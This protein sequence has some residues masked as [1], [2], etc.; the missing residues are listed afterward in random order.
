MINLAIT[1]KSKLS[2]VEVKEK[3]QREQALTKKRTDKDLSPKERDQF[4]ILYPITQ[5]ELIA[6]K[7]L[8]S[9]SDVER[10]S[11]ELQVF[12]DPA[13]TRSAMQE[14]QKGNIEGRVGKDGNKFAPGY[15]VTQMQKRVTE[16]ESR[17]IMSMLEEG[18]D[19]KQM[20][21]DLAVAC[22]FRI[23]KGMLIEENADGIFVAVNQAIDSYHNILKTLF[24]MEN[25][26]KVMVGADD[27]LRDLILKN[28]GF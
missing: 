4:R 22:Q 13:Y 12:K 6:Q 5:N 7:F 15:L 28:Q 25:G 14:A 10:L 21:E 11:H 24:E 9:T 20:L 23:N 18:V 1:K 27:S 26:Q 8:I 3:V 19:P 16:E 2:L 17:E